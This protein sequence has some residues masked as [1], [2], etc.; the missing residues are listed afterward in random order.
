MSG[1]QI[2]DLGLAAQKRRGW[3]PLSVW[4]AIFALALATFFG[5]W[6]WGSQAEASTAIIYYVD[7]GSSGGFACMP[8]YGYDPASCWSGGW[9]WHWL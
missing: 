1:R 8:S 2:P 5:S 7:P 4:L 3:R 6:G 9:C